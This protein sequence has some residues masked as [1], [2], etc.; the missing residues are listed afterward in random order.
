MAKYNQLEARPR[1]NHH[2]LIT[3][4]PVAADAAIGSMDPKTSLHCEG[5]SQVRCLAL[6]TGGTTPAIN[7]EQLGR[8]QYENA[9]G[10]E[11]D[12]LVLQDTFTGIGDGE[13]FVAVVNGSP[14]L[15]RISAVSGSPTQVEILVS[16][17]IKE[18]SDLLAV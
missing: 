14:T 17:D 6:L 2:R 1:Y 5:W 7:V 12:T 10:V 13:E 11:V 16:G 3:G 15:F 9:S 18:L 8:V 4:S